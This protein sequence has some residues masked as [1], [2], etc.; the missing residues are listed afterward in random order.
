[1]ALFDGEGNYNDPLMWWKSHATNY[2][3]LHVLAMKVLQVQ[4][5]SAASERLFSSAGL[6]ITNDRAR[7]LPENAAMLVFLKGAWS[8]AEELHGSKI[9]HDDD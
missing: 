1:M 6:T 5:T 4:A 7:L 9:T 2:P 3:R 8:I